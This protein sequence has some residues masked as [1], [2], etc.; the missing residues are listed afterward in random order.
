MRARSRGSKLQKQERR[1]RNAARGV[2]QRWN[3]Q[4]PKAPARP[5]RSDRR[6]G[7]SPARAGL[8]QGERTGGAVDRA[9]RATGSAR[10]HDGPSAE[11]EVDRRAGGHGGDAQRPA[12][13]SNAAAFE[14]VDLPGGDGGGRGRG[15]TGWS[16]GVVGSGELSLDRQER[17]AGDSRSAHDGACL[18]GAASRKGGRWAVAAES[19]ALLGDQAAAASAVLHRPKTV[20]FWPSESGMPKLF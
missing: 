20:G 1:Q 15:G 12:R 6:E 11:R 2:L 3:L 9:D 14:E 10:E 13:R 16:G 4:G 8:S 19:G 18:G 17:G 7:R 5:A